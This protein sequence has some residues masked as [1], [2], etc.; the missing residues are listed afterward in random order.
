M[1]W[2]CNRLWSTQ[3]H[4]DGVGF[5]ERSGE[6]SAGDLTK[7]QLGCV[8]VAG[9]PASGL[10]QGLPGN[11]ALCAQPDACLGYEGT[12]HAAGELLGRLFP[13]LAPTG[14]S[15]RLFGGAGGGLD[16]DESDEEAIEALSE[17]L[18]RVSQEN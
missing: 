12:L 10:A 7:P 4:V 8:Q 5:G 14:S 6:G 9:A 1:C 2:A 13:E 3:A 15:S 16:G 18:G 11:V 17:A